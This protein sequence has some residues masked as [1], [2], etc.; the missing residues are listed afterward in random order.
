M[1]KLTW[2]PI[3]PKRQAYKNEWGLAPLPNAEIG[4]ITE[5]M[6]KAGKSAYWDHFKSDDV[7]AFSNQI[8]AIYEAMADKKQEDA[9]RSIQ[10]ANLGL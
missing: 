1:A 8:K 9:I 2:G 7:D 4:M 3:A 5:S 10:E 6:I